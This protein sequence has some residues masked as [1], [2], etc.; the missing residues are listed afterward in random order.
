MMVTMSDD[1]ILFLVD[2]LGNLVDTVNGAFV[3]GNTAFTE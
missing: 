2:K 1:D 3:E